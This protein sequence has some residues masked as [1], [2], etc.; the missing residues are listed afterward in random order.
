LHEGVPGHHLQASLASEN[1]ALPAL[2]RFGWSTGFGEGWALYAEMLGKEMGL[3]TDPYQYFGRLDMEMLRAVRLVVDTGLHAKKWSRQQA[4][5][6]MLAHTALDAAAVEQEIDRYIVWPGQA[7][8]YKVG[9]LFIRD[10]RTKAQQAL[11]QRFD[12]RAFHDEVLNTGAIPLDVLQK[13][14]DSW[15]AQVKNSP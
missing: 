12:L 3:Y 7:T 14:I 2:L 8:A 13:K 5:D 9:E 11:G 6:T 10:L 1:T 15:I 4:I